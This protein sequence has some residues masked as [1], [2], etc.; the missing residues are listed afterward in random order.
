MTKFHFFTLSIVLLILTSCGSSKKAAAVAKVEFEL[1]KQYKL[2]KGIPYKWGGTDRRGFD[3]S[4]FVGKVYKDA[5]KTQ[6]PRTVK[7]IATKGRK[8]SKFKLKPGDLVFF[9]PSRKY[10]HVGI[11]IGDNL[12]MHSSTSKGIIK[13]KMDNVY[14]KKKFRYAKR[15]LTY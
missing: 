14:W 4:G 8:I 11:Y 3:C 1:E 2:Y 6:L 9:R 15:I 12:F 13:S 5:L 7:E 10:R